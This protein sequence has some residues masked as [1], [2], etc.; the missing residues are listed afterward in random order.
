MPAS[1]R[2]SAGR[3]VPGAGNGFVPETPRYTACAA[4]LRAEFGLSTIDF[5]FEKL[6]RLHPFLRYP[7]GEIPSD[8]GH[9]LADSGPTARWHECSQ[10]RF[11]LEVKNTQIHEML[12]PLSRC[13]P[14][15]CFVNCEICLDDCSI[16][17]AFT[18]RGRQS[19]WD[20]PQARIDAHWEVTAKQ[21]SV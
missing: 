19:K 13:Y 8:G 5:S 4:P 11:T 3:E 6:F 2:R 14:E 1:A 9:Y 21:H 7:K 18:R 12:L 10:A 15:V 16:A 17:S 20:L